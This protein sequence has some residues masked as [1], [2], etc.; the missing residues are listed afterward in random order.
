MYVQYFSIISRFQGSLNTVTYITYNYHM[1]GNADIITSLM[2]AYCA[3][4][5]WYNYARQAT[6][7]CGEAL[8][9]NMKVKNIFDTCTI[10]TL[11]LEIAMH[12]YIPLAHLFLMDICM[13]KV[14]LH[15]LT[16]APGFQYKPSQ[17]MST[18]AGSNKLHSQ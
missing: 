8:Y 17:A 4:K 2:K 12:I 13:E 18:K 5:V 11:R 16:H 1:K 10:S 14:Q 3:N 9:V 15:T 7:R 6:A